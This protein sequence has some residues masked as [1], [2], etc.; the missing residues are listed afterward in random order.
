MGPAILQNMQK[1]KGFTLIELSIVLV[2]IGI[3]LYSGIA[4][5]AIQIEA[6]KLKQT[7]DKLNKIE[8]AMQ[9]YFEANNSLPCPAGGNRAFNAGDFAM[10]EKANASSALSNTTCP[11][12]DTTTNDAA[13]GANIYIGVVPTRD[14]D[15]PDDFMMDGWGNRITYAVSKH[16]VDPDNW[17]DADLSA[18]NKCTTGADDT[19]DG[20]DANGAGDLSYEPGGNIIVCNNSAEV[21]AGT[22]I[23][24]KYAAYVILSHGKN[25]VGG[26]TDEGSRITTASDSSPFDLDNAN[27]VNA[28]GTG[29][30]NYNDKFR[31][32]MVADYEGAS[33]T[34][35]FD[36]VVLWKTAP[37]IWFEKYH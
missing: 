34:V 37:Q 2:I 12:V 5:G 28:D 29:G 3:M 17:S 36:D 23:R 10:G 25:G 16:C 21:C 32:A 15:L 33:P 8:K 11:N 30:D 7:K 22:A 19:N 14:L 31:D 9:L 26:W 20:T 24:S 6:A 13:G 18:T 27:R 4:I 35:Y 1:K